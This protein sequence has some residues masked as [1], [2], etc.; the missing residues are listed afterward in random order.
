MLANFANLLAG[1]ILLSPIV[2][3]GYVY[4]KLSDPDW[5]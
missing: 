2:L 1:F 3:A 5:R 4:L